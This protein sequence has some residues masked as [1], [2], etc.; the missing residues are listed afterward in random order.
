MT[1]I[2]K[3]ARAMELDLAKRGILHS[4]CA[5]LARAALEAMREP[6]EAMFLVGNDTYEYDMTPERWCSMIDAALAEK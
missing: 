1:M 5:L 3:I 4:E 6:T 2:E